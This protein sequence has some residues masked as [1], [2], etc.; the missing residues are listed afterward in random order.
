VWIGAYRFQGKIYQV[1]VNAR[2]GEVHGERPWS[3]A[4]LA[5]LAALVLAV[6]LFVVWMSN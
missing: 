1:V 4:K 6:I 2:T 3:V 5:L